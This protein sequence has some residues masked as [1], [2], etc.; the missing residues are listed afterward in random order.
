MSR[1][2]C[3]EPVAIFWHLNAINYV[4]RKTQNYKGD[5]KIGEMKKKPS[6]EIIEKIND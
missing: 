2:D 1:F 4:W 5:N 6:F 3:T